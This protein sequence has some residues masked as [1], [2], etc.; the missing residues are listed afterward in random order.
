LEASGLFC[1]G[2]RQR[3]LSKVGKQRTYG[4][5]SENMELSFFFPVPKVKGLRAALPFAALFELLFKE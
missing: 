5:L 1:S 2:W 3:L 4:H